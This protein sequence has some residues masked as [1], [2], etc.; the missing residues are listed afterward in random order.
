VTAGEKQGDHKE[1]MGSIS[2][3]NTHGLYSVMPVMQQEERR[4][5]RSR[6]QQLYLLLEPGSGL[7][8]KSLLL[9]QQQQQQQQQP[10][11]EN[12]E[13]D[14][15]MLL[16]CYPAPETPQEPMEFLSRSWSI[17]SLDIARALASKTQ[18]TG[19]GDQQEHRVRTT[20]T[21]ADEPILQTVPFTFA[22]SIT[23]QLVMERIMTP[24][25]E[26]S[27]VTSRRNSHSS[28]PLGLASPPHSPHQ[29]EN[30]RVCNFF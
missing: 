6:E 19:G 10:V 22:S 4:R 2:R 17:S 1:T 13:E 14:C 9:S 16:P 28:G 26:L 29:M 21:E 18:L 11:L 3:S 25:A 15:P 30:Y 8:E 12:I 24:G 5:R 7:R 23:S 20:A 27:P